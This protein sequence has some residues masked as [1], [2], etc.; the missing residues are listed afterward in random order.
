[1][2]VY[3]IFFIS[4]NFA[5]Q[6]NVHPHNISYVTCRMSYVR[7]HMS[8]V[9]CHMSG[10]TCHISHFMFHMQCFLLLFFLSEKVFVAYWWRVS[11][12]RGLPRLVFNSYHTHSCHFELFQNPGELAQAY[13][14]DGQTDGQRSNSSTMTI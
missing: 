13:H 2:W 8:C 11:Y 5:N 4:D 6:F 3:L 10:V 12:Q 14:T 1:M 9:M 7:C